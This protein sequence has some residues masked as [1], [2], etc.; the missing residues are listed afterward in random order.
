[1]AAFEI[2]VDGQSFFGS[3]KLLALLTCQVEIPREGVRQGH[4]VHQ[5]SSL[6]FVVGSECLVHSTCRRERGHEGYLSS[7]V[8]GV[9]LGGTAGGGQRVVRTACIQIEHGQVCINGGIRGCDIAGGTLSNYWIRN[10][11]TLAKR[12][13]EGRARDEG[14]DKAGQDSLHNRVIGHSEVAFLVSEVRDLPYVDEAGPKS[15]ERGYS[16]ATRY[17]SLPYQ[18]C[19]AFS[20]GQPLIASFSMT[21]DV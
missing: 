20:T 17:R 5:A 3:R 16:S 8:Q 2:I 7:G 11:P 9:E 19:W 14:K 12:I 15:V 21:L 1:M 10:L 4:R 6:C 13:R 18:S